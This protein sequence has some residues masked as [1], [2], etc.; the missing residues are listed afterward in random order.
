MIY[1]YVTMESP[2]G[3]LRI[4]VRTLR[5]VG[6]KMGFQIVVRDQVIVEGRGDRETLKKALSIAADEAIDSPVAQSELRIMVSQV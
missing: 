3:E 1:E 2:S 5:W 4:Q 6:K